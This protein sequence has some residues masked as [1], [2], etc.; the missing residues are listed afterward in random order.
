MR[1]TKD[2][3]KKLERIVKYDDVSNER[4]ELVVNKFALVLNEVNWSD[5]N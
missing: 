4:A 3:Y 2:I 1:A 5:T